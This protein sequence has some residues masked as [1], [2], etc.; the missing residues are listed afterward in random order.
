MIWLRR[1][2]QD[3]KIRQNVDAHVVT[4]V[5]FSFAVVSIFGD[6]VPDQ[7]K[8]AALL[9]GVGILVYRLTLPE[10]RPEVSASILGDRSAFD[11][12]PLSSAL[13]N[14]R[15]V[16]IFAP[17]AVN[18]L[19]A[20]TCETLRRTVLARA[21]GS[22][23]VVILD[24]AEKAAVRMASKQ[25]DDSVE[26]PIQRL[27]AALSSAVERLDLMS[28]WEVEGSFR[29][30]LLSYSP[31]FSIVLIDPDSSKGRAI[32][33]IHGFHNPST[34]SRMHLELNRA[35]NERWYSYWVRQFDYIWREATQADVSSAAEADDGPAPADAREGRGR[36]L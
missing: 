1:L 13:A 9:S 36:P 22:V 11:S 26:F 21:G 30:R 35:R 10:E 2:V 31:G 15:D 23:R 8:W 14:A 7:L 29:Y 28:G 20:H 18:L 34:S 16:R 24:P 3:L 12:V 25:L 33:E 32:V 5:V 6:V 27:P 4:V 17:S 19:S